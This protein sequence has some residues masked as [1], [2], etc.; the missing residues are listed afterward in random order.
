[1]VNKDKNNISPH[2]GVKPKPVVIIRPD[3]E[4]I[5][6]YPSINSCARAIGVSR[7]NMSEDC[8]SG[9]LCRGYKIMFEDDWSPLGDYSYKPKK[10][11]DIYGRLQKGHKLFALYYGMQTKEARE[12]LRKARS[13]LSKKRC[14]DPNSRWGGGKRNLKKVWCSTTGQ[15]FESIKE[16]A[17][18]HHI[19]R[20]YLSYAIHK[21]KI[22][23]G[24]KF[25]FEK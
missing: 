1:M 3:G 15:H 16:A 20:G 23:K 2:R 18:C 25:H 13:E 19:T 9:Y 21:G 8:K 14:A 11:R 7:Q 10:G 17:E 4:K 12:K 22:T 5:R 6:T 24:L